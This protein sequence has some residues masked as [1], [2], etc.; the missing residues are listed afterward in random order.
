MP[1]G[2]RDPVL[3]EYAR[4]ANRYDRRWSFYIDATTRETMKRLPLRPGDRLIDIGCGTGA[5]LHA[6]SEANGEASLVGVDPTPEMMRIARERLPPAVRLVL[7]RG[8][9]LP[10]RDESFD[11]AVS[12][13]VFHYFRQ[14]RVALAEIARVLRPRGLVVIT[15]WCGN[16]LACRVCDRILR[17]I[18]R[19]HFRAYSREECHALIESAKFE[20]I[21]IECYKINWLWGLMNARA[22]KVCA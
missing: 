15:D 17:W 5:L 13:S 16:Y 20:S 8:E 12:A 2:G 3:E 10:F 14:P 9:R 6:L 18:N 7:G 21:E 11:V 19:A 22:V 1:T 4:L